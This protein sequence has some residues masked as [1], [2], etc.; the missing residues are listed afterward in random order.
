[1]KRACASN[2]TRNPCERSVEKS[3]CTVTNALA[4]VTRETPVSQTLEKE[5]IN[6]FDPDSPYLGII[7]QL[8]RFPT[9][10]YEELISQ[11]TEKLPA[12]RE[13]ISAWL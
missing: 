12:I 4:R 8:F 2:L 6:E 11:A 10:Q 3:S 13:W 1:M 5:L 7:R 9:D